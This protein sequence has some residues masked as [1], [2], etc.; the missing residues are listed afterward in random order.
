MTNQ[1]LISIQNSIHEALHVV[2][3]IQDDLNNKGFVPGAEGDSL[4]AL[5]S[6]QASRRELEQ[7][8]EHVSYL[9]GY[10]A[11]DDAA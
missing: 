10:T 3:Q 11:E 7:A 5:I 1:E 9:I 2:R 4:T 8:V 6:V